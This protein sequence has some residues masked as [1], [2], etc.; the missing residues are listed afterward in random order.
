MR[1]SSCLHESRRSG[2]DPPGSGSDP[3]GYGCGKPL[4][5]AKRTSTWRSLYATTSDQN[6]QKPQFERNTRIRPDPTSENKNPES[7]QNIKKKL[8]NL[9]CFKIRVRQKN[10]NHYCIQT[11]GEKKQFWIKAIKN[12]AS[13]LFQ[14]LRIQEKNI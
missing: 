2:S 6:L 12:P 11:P 10:L 9:I 13:K 3:P 1:K 5:G 8:F 4:L 7:D 14:L